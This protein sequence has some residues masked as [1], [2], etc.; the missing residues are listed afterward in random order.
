MKN[1][2]KFHLGR[3]DGKRLQNGFSELVNCDIHSEIGEVKCQLKL[4][5]ESASTVNHACYTAIAPNGDAYFFSSTTGNIYKRTQAGV[6]S[7]VR[8]N[9]NGSHKGALYYDGYIY[10]T[11]DDKL[12]RF[13]LSTTWSDSWQSL[14][15][16]KN[17]SMEQFD[18]IL[19]ICNGTD[20]ASV[21][22]TGTFT[23][24]ALDIPEQFESVSLKQF[25]DDLLVLGNADYITDS[26]IFRWNTYSST[27]TVSDAVKE[28]VFCFIDADNYVF[29]LA[30]S[31][32]IYQ[33]NGSTLIPSF[34]IDTFST[35]NSQLACSYKGKALFANGTKIWS[36][37][38]KNN[39]MP[40]VLCGEYTCNGTIQSL[41]AS[42]DD[43]LVSYATGVDNIATNR[44]D[45]VITTP[46]YTG[47]VS[48]VEVSYYD[49]PTGTD[50]NIETKIDG[51]SWTE[52]TELIDDVDMKTVSLASDIINLKDIQARVTLGASTTKTPIIDNIKIS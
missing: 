32:R 7:S 24:S 10:Y 26:K 38:R 42:G 20:V 48:Q 49:L 21:D 30:V 15:S 11:T 29:V 40:F 13:D 34:N 50:I 51:G 36:L 8:V 35:Y 47:R 25:G 18:L 46:L 52:Q 19:Y 39:S 2:S 12:G 1:Y 16:G 27:W 41:R 22:D 43:L 14:T 45:A 28:P 9:G 6:Y 33:F 44:A 4:E 37:Y 23:S 17:H 31:G 5:K 3:Q